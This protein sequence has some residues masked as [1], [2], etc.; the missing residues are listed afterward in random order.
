MAFEWKRNP[1]ALVAMVVAR[2]MAVQS[3]GW[4][5]ISRPRPARPLMI[6]SRLMVDVIS[7]KCWL[8]VPGS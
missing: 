7:A 2:K 1:V 6:A 4:A 5:C 3:P 8:K